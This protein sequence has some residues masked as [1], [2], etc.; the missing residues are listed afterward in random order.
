MFASFW[1][2]LLFFLFLLAVSGLLIGIGY[3]WNPRRP[4]PVKAMPYESG[5]DPFH[6]ARRR[7]DVRFYL[8]AVAFLVFDVEIL[9]LYPWAVAAGLGRQP[10]VVA[11]PSPPEATGVISSY[12]QRLTEAFGPESAS[13]SENTCSSEAPHQTPVGIDGAVQAGMIES[14][15]MVLAGA[16]VFIGLLAIGYLYDW[17]KGIFQWR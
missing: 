13:A 12:G 11:P 2:V 6:D 7:L 5:M 8:L 10:M 3:V 17:R 14:R 4:N 16:L 1:P 9:L 15:G